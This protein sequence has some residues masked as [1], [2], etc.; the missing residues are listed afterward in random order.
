MP[1][2]D[3]MQAESVMLSLGVSPRTGFLIEE[4]QFSYDMVYGGPDGFFEYARDIN[5][6][7]G[8]LPLRI[9]NKS[10]AKAV[11][12]LPEFNYG[13]FENLSW[14]AA[15]NLMLSLTM[16]THAYLLEKLGYKT[17]EELK[18]DE[19]PKLLDKKL[20]LPLYELH[21]I[22]G[23]EPSASYCFYGLWN[24]RRT[25]PSK[26]ITV[27]NVRMRF[28][29]T[30]CEDEHWF[31]G[32]HNDVEV[33]F[34]PA[35]N[36]MLMAAMLSHVPAFSAKAMADVLAQAIT[37]NMEVVRSLNRVRERCRA[38]FYFNQVRMFFSFP[39]NVTFE[40]VPAWQG[41]EILGETGGQSP[42]QHFRL[43]ILG[44]KHR[45]PYFP[46]MRK[47]MQSNFQAFLEIADKSRVREF[48]LDK[49]NK[50]LD[51]VYNSLVRAVIDWRDAHGRLA[52]EYV[53]SL[54]DPDGTSK[55][56]VSWLKHLRDET[57]KKLIVR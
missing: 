9:K 47:H 40:D 35:I 51:E 24:Y 48:V 31:V 15:N 27:D 3:S 26:P 34:A 36:P 33:T 13:F 37:P 14:P 23:V 57:E 17:V 32:T 2:E 39:R 41:R 28:S 43:A 12:R 16:I 20:A 25:K 30:A 11:S 44:I 49:N 1:I 52:Q 29:Y 46:K 56:P 5:L 45:D 38:D 54:G 10:V 8:N 4:S 42:F 53:A 55:A 18:Q 19:S 21:L 50:A 22:T 7:A 6:V